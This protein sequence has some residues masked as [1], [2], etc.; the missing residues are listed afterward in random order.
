MTAVNAIGCRVILRVKQVEDP[1]LKRAQAMGIK[2][3]PQTEEDQKRAQAGVD[4]VVVLAIGPNCSASWIGGVKIGDTV[5]FAKYSGKLI[6]AL[7]NPE[8][9]YLI[10]NDEDILC[11]YRSTN[12]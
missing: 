2:L 5:A 8:D 9:K 1:V 12:G 3:A 11:T 7:D 10:L 6:S 4:Q